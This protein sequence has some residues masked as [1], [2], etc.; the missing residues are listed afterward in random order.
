MNF[1]SI[2]VVHP[3]ASMNTATAWNKSCFILSDFDM[4]DNLLIAFQAFTRYML[5][6]FSVDGM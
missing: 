3:Y 4:N 1:V 6:S 2:R 5:A